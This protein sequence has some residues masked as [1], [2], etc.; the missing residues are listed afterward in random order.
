M[1]Q[2]NKEE[3]VQIEGE[4]LYSIPLLESASAFLVGAYIVNDYFWYGCDKTSEAAVATSDY[5]TEKATS[6]VDACTCAQHDEAP[7]LVDG[8]KVERPV[9]R[10]HPGE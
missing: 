2:P 6:A 5:V 1:E 10:S 3:G 4:K 8:V 9:E 7:E